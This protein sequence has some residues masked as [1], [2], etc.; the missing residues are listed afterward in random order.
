M[1]WYVNVIVQLQASAYDYKVIKEIIMIWKHAK[2]L[3]KKLCK[4]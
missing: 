4:S 1:V 2:T 3:V